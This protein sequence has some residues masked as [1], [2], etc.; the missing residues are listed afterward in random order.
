VTGGVAV[1]LEVP[2]CEVLAV[3]VIEGEIVCDVENDGDVL[4]F[5]IENCNSQPVKNP[6]SDL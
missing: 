4:E 5:V 6:V 1:K 3:P 2:V